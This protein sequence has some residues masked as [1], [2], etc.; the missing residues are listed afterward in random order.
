MNEIYVIEREW[1]SQNDYG[2]HESKIEDEH[3]FFLTKEDAEAV[4]DKLNT[5][6]RAD[7]EKYYTKPARDRW[8]AEARTIK[9]M[10]EDWDF[11]NLHGRASSKRPSDPRPFNPP[12]DH[13]IDKYSVLAIEAH[14]EI[15]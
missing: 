5:K 7:F 13:I 2:D 9:R 8:T 10:Q 15:A 11:L 14:K 1:D 6:Q 4:A 3:G 12:S